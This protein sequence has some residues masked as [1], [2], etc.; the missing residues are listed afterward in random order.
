MSK[1]WDIVCGSCNKGAGF[2]VRSAIFLAPL[3]EHIE[4]WAMMG[5]ALGEV[6]TRFGYDEGS[7]SAIRSYPDFAETHA[8]H[9]ILLRASS[10]EIRHLER[11]RFPLDVSALAT[12][13]LHELLGR[14]TEEAQRRLWNWAS[15]QKILGRWDSF[16]AVVKEA[17]HWMEGKGE[18]GVAFV[19]RLREVR[20][21]MGGQP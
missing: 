9:N 3:A 10:G 7:E 2:A 19:K 15:A 20:M 18:E 17:E 11:K 16:N 14:V 12:H 13:S 4:S 5:E 8:S 6:E 21:G 1:H